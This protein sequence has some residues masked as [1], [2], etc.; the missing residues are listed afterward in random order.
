MCGAGLPVCPSV[1]RPVGAQTSYPSLP[2]SDPA[3]ASCIYEQTP[4]EALRP[5]E[6]GWPVP[7]KATWIK[8]DYLQG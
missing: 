1:A 3:C 7:A 8:M 2:A 6:Q 4:W 5:L